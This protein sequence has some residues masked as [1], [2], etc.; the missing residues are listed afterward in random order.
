MV[1]SEEGLVFTNHH[2]GYGA[3][4][5]LSAVEHDYLRDGL[6]LPARAMN[7]CRRSYSLL[8]PFDGDVTDRIAPHVPLVMSEIQREL[9]IDS[10]SNEL[11]SEYESDPFTRARV[12]PFFSRN[13]YYVVL[14][15]L[16]RD[17]RMVVAPPSSVGKFGGDT[18]NWMWPRHTGDFSVF[19]VYA[20]K[21]NQPQYMPIMY[22]ISPNMW[23]R[24]RGRAT[25]G[26]YAMTGIPGSTQRYLPH[27]GI[28]QRMESENKPRIEVR[29][30][31]GDMVGC[32]DSE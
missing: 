12:I 30:I 7:S 16:F 10:I 2:C 29:G 28:R 20:G 5:Q 26:D 31:S 6:R 18:D 32:H 9:A 21:D 1:V 3:I 24:Y 19:R 15:D 27:G 4:Q 8:S 22:P 25:E 23:Y 14:Y 13:K 17:V 11:I